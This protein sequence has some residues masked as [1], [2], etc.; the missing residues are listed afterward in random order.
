MLRSPKSL[1]LAAFLT[2]PLTTGCTPGVSEEELGTIHKDVPVVPGGDQ[3]YEL[4][5][6]EQPGEDAPPETT[7]VEGDSEDG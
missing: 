7:Q 2:L 5:E 3:P 1:L 4:P 6:L